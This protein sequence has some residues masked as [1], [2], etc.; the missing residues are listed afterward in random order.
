MQVSPTSFN[1]DSG[2]AAV[3]HGLG[4]L[5]HALRHIG[6]GICAAG[7]HRGYET[8]HQ[9]VLVNLQEDFPVLWQVIHR[10]VATRPHGGLWV[11]RPR[12]Q[13]LLV[14]TRLPER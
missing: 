11:S 6:I 2:P 12:E 9:H 7:K 4:R 14:L 13:A 1:G 3:H 8:A 10:R 5:N